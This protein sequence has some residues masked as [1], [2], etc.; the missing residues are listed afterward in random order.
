MENKI[1]IK[2]IDGVFTP[3][4]AQTLL[5]T[6]IDNKINYHKIDDFS[7]H[8][9][10]DRDSQHS[11]QRILEL[12]ETKAALRAWIDLVQKDSSRFIV[13]STVTIEFDENILQS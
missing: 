13:K 11:K 9:R 10:Y 5:T 4:E 12:V 6:L 2:L 1:E 7:N 3:S 8:I